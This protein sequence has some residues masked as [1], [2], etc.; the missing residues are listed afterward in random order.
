MTS[1]KPFKSEN[2]FF[3]ARLLVISCFLG[4]PAV[5]VFLGSD[6]L[7]RLHY[8]ERKNHLSRRLV[9]RLDEIEPFK[10]EKYFC[11]TILES[12]IKKALNSSSPRKNLARAFGYLKTKYSKNLS[13]VV[14]DSQGKVIPELTNVKIYRFVAGKVWESLKAVVCEMRKNGAMNSVPS[15]VIR[16]GNLLKSFLGRMLLISRID[17]P[18]RN[19][20][21]RIPIL[22]SYKSKLNYLWYEI[23][24]GFSVL[25]FVDRRIFN[26]RYG[27]KKKLTAQNRARPS[28]DTPIAG[29]YEF[30]LAKRP[31]LGIKYPFQNELMSALAEYE[32]A[33]VPVVETKN[34]I[35]CIRIA[36]SRL[37]LFTFFNK[38][39]SLPDIALNRIRAIRI[40]VLTLLL[41]LL[42]IVT[43]GFRRNFLNSMRWELV[44]IFFYVNM[45]PVTV[46]LFQARD[47]L[48]DKKAALVYKAQNAIEHKLKNFDRNFQTYLK[49][50][51]EGIN[52]RL[53]NFNCNNPSDSGESRAFEDLEAA[54]EDL[55][56][57]EILLFNREGI[58]KAVR[59]ND[60]EGKK[61]ASGQFM[62]K[63]GVSI[64][65][66]LN[67][68]DAA[69]YRERLRKEL[70]F[71]VEIYSES[72]VESA[73]NNLGKIK[74]MSFGA[75]NKW[76]Y[77]GV[78]R[79]KDAE[80]YSH[81]FMAAW[82]KE[83]LAGLFLEKYLSEVSEN[84]GMDLVA[85]LTTN[86]KVYPAGRASN[87]DMLR[88]FDRIRERQSY[89]GGTIDISGDAFI[90]VGILGKC[91]DTVC[92]LGLMPFSRIE[93]EVSEIRLY[94]F[95]FA[96]FSVFLVIVAG[97][98]W[99]RNFIAPVYSME[100]AILEMSRR[101][102]RH[103]IPVQGSDEFGVLAK[104][105]NRAIEGLEEL[106]VAGIV[107]ENLLPAMG[108]SKGNIAVNG[109]T[110]RITELMADYYDFFEVSSSG[111]GMLL[112]D[113]S[114]V[115]ISAA[116][117]MTM[118]KAAVRLSDCEKENPVRLLA[119][120]NNLLLAVH[121]D[122]FRYRMSF[123]YMLVDSENSYARWCNAGIC[124]PILVNSA[125]GKA[126]FLAQGEMDLGIDEKH[127]YTEYSLYLK[128]GEAI[129][130]YSDGVVSG[131]VEGESAMSEKT[132]L[133]WALN[134]FDENP[135][136]Y[137]SNL[138]SRR[139][140]M[141]NRCDDLTVL[142]IVALPG[143]RSGIDEC[144]FESAVGR[145]V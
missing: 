104:T 142:A 125:C 75:E 120:I 57:S 139:P 95:L 21:S 98:F 64:L 50:L 33:A 44:C 38:N 19:D 108:I 62:E 135:K 117:F 119:E 26:G 101:N 105:F 66:Y 110:L 40:A 12:I 59:L 81:L 127:V 99:S 109:R 35:V 83:T 43:A 134:C 36:S 112:A 97:V 45:L 17:L 9:E 37:R 46:M 129:I 137:C 78:V 123:L 58:Q 84:M 47:Y 28:T 103:R 42:L 22:V 13:F 31:F 60:A 15:E 56:I 82:D 7:S 102:F 132:L 94:I 3:L 70:V 87:P 92:Y 68:K 73:V 111:I 52:Y 6:Q 51:E 128:P 90:P 10:D 55:Q 23:S 107:Q 4:F 115:G 16:N 30:P 20:K 29:Y 71:E 63:L 121:R 85:R 65:D 96:I 106:N 122:E 8:D 144:S 93:K 131:A 130:V 76:F 54:L 11:R 39:K 88:L 1:E 143:K 41:P 72:Y 124:A 67:G 34:L 116:M 14:W 91:L 89:Y 79:R 141:K 133:E 145:A 138:I 69:D 118:T 80:Y 2:S 113:V 136:N 77:M 48:A 74:E 53:Q 100:E 86:H 24:P 27:L 5:L 49:K 25:C 32:N 61:A 18:V 126:K 114:A 140:A